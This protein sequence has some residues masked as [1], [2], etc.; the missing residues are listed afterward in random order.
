M[1]ASRHPA[2][3]ELWYQ[4]LAS[5]LLL[6]YACELH[7]APWHFRTLLSCTALCLCVSSLCRIFTPALW[8]LSV[9]LLA[10][11]L[12][13]KPFLVANHHYC[14]FY[15][16]LV[17]LVASTR[18]PQER[19]SLLE[20]NARFLAIVIMG[21]AVLQKL[22]SPSYMNGDYLGFMW[23]K[24]SYFTPFTQLLTPHIEQVFQS[25]LKAIVAFRD[26]PPSPES[27]VLLAEPFP[28]YGPVVWFSVWSILIAEFLAALTL[29]IFPTAVMTLILN[30]SVVLLIAVARQEFVFLSYYF[31][32]LALSTGG[33]HVY[34]NIVLLSASGILSLIQI[35]L[36][37]V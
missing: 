11:H 22:F 14:L 5:L 3:V 10:Q 36:F 26:S 8:G 2:W 33:R 30:G 6:A 13:A 17:L 37:L 35:Y 28:L 29:L 7:S 24:G 9:I 16:S 23:A 1:A 31:L 27:A 15:L 34:A 19:P 25:N 12:F 21:F 18:P 4:L 20:S 32:L